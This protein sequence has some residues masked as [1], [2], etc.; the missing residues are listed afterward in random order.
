MSILTK[1]RHLVEYL[2]LRGVIALVRALPLD[3]ATSWSA[4]AWAFIA[5][6]TQRHKRALANLEKAFPEKSL[7]ERE[8][9]AREMWANLGRVMAETMRLDNI[10]DEPERV[11]VENAQL[12][13]R[14]RGRMGP[15]ICASM[16]MGNWELA[17]LP[18]TRAEAKPAAVY[19][20]VDNPYVD[21]YLR[22]QRE[23]LYPGGLFARG[24]KSGYAT[25][26]VIG[27]YVRQGGRLGFLADRYDR[28]G[29]RVPFF[30]H[31]ARSNTVPAMLA[32]RLGARLWLGRC[33]RVGEGSHFKVLVKEL[34]VPRTDD[35]DADIKWIVEQM[36]AQ[37]EAWIREHP[38]QW[39]WSNRRYS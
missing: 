16:H 37:F 26:R 35:P 25:A 6:K 32:R 18:L 27:S 12:L 22:S 30:G 39:M 28:T 8:R 33:I 2:L 11:E 34:K 4:K 17:M 3:T 23:K 14:Y 24:A 1:A 10:L 20:L 21:M 31:P 19:R 5:P 9:I 36:Q 29:I 15:A 13:E 38:E 7:E